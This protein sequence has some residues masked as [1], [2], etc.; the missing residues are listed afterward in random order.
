MGAEML[1]LTKEQQDLLDNLL[2]YLDAE[3]D[4]VAFQSDTE[5][6]VIVRRTDGDVKCV[7]DPVA[8]E[9]AFRQ[10]RGP[11]PSNP[12][13][14]MKESLQLSSIHINESVAIRRGSVL[15]M[16][17]RGVFYHPSDYYAN[18]TPMPPL[19]EVLVGVFARAYKAGIWVV[20]RVLDERR[21][22][23]VYKNDSSENL[24]GRVIDVD[25]LWPLLDTKSADSMS[26]FLIDALALPANLG[27]KEISDLAMGLVAQPE[28]VNWIS[29]LAI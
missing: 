2:N 8:L 29:P 15:Y 7:I 12:Y 9:L 26:A 19:D 23:L 10:R 22:V 28:N 21:L 13:R 3:S 4:K 1:G 14:T 27:G 17:K 24:L 20:G 5:A 11:D 18:L 25:G 6:G 16:D